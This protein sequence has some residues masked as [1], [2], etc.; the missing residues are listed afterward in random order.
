MSARIW[1]EP[2]F[3][4]QIGVARAEITPGLE[5]YARNWGASTHDHAVGVHRPLT[6][7]VLTIQSAPGALPLVLVSADLGWWRSKH[8]ERLVRGGILEALELPEANVLVCLTHTH[9]GPVLT[10]QAYLS[11]LRQTLVGLTQQALASAQAATMTVAT[12]TCPLAINRDL[13][14]PSAPDTYWTGFNPDAP[15]PDQTL[16]VARITANADL[17]T[18]AT[19]VNYACHPTVLGPDNQQLSPDYIGAL[20]EVVEGVTQGA[21]CLF[22]QGASGELSARK[23]YSADLSLAERHGRCVGY[24]ALS[25]LESLLPASHALAFCGVRS[26]GAPL[27]L[28]EYTLQT[29]PS[30]SCAPALLSVPL[31]LKPLATRAELERALAQSTD[32]AEQERL[33]RRLQVRDDV[34]DADTL[35]YPVWVWDFGPIALVAHPGEAY[36][37]LQTRL[38]QRF[39][40]K[41]IF[42]VNVANGWFGYLPPRELYAKTIYSVTQTPLAEGCLEAVIEAIDL[43]TGGSI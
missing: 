5:I 32:N 36:S 42:V 14:D 28:W 39:P 22:L 10:D 34:G 26:S 20:R 40:E 30:P 19:L 11:Q 23:Q 7:A 4:A 6:A 37:A 18:L 2:S 21:P 41:A 13:P 35:A 1:S 33:R 9:A 38:R 24:A 17:S 27:A 16:L 29:P 31:P 25:A 15:L 12:T 8:D 3:T 43:G